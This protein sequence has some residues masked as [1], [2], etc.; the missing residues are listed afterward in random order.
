MAQVLDRVLST[1]FIAA[2]PGEERD[3]VARGVLGLL[4]SDEQTA[5]RDPLSLPYR[6]DV[7]S[8]ER[9]G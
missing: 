6:T 8:C 7:Y 2:L 9:L 1:S 4:D 3:R 5:G